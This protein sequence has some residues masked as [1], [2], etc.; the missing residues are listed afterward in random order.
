MYECIVNTEATDTL[1]LNH[2]A[3][4]IQSADQVTIVLNKFHEKNI[5]FTATNKRNYVTF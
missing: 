1:V 5:A 2:Q 3:I 4:S